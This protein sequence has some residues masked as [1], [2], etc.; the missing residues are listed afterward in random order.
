MMIH[1]V[2]LISLQ[3]HLCDN[4]TVLNFQMSNF[5]YAFLLL[6]MR[7]TEVVVVFSK[8]QKGHDHPY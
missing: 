6:D 7:T 1:V 3:M 8:V 5:W 4:L 2:V